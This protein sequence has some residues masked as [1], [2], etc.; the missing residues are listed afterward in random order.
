MTPQQVQAWREA[1][2]GRRFLMCMGAH[3]INTALFV[4]GPLDQS[5]YLTTFGGTVAAYLAV[6]GWQKHVE[7][8]TR[9]E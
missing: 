7:A 9:S 1:L 3:F 8:K 6:A 4:W 2:G 5:G